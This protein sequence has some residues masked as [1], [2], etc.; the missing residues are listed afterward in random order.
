L[1]MALAA[2]AVGSS[3]SAAPT[4]PPTIRLEVWSSQRFEDPFCSDDPLEFFFRVDEC[5]YLTIYQVNPWGGVDIIYPRPP[6][7]WIAVLPRRTYCLTDLAPDIYLAYEGVE[8]SAHIGIIATH[9]PIDLVPWLESGFR[10]YGF[11][12]GRPAVFHSSINVNVVL[13]HIQADLRFRL[14]RYCEPTFFTRVIHL[15]PRPVRRPP[16]VIYR[17]PRPGWHTWKDP[18]SGWPNSPSPRSFS[19]RH[20]DLEGR[21]ALPPEK[22]QRTISKSSKDSSPSRPV[23]A[24]ERRVRKPN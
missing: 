21:E 10:S 23:S 7:R 19:K 18:R 14:G 4:V 22:K 5:A 9:D 15:R 13:D 1:T 16:V 24:K 11:V 12:F 6:H 3:A 2:C 8:G 20:S 17:A